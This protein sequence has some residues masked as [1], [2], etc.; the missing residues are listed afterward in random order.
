MIRKKPI[1]LVAIILLI[2]SIAFLILGISPT[3]VEIHHVNN[4]ITASI[5][6]RNFDNYFKRTVTTIDNVKYCS[7]YKREQESNKHRSTRKEFYYSVI[8]E[9]SDDKSALVVQKYNNPS[10]AND[11]KDKINDAIF[12]KTDLKHTFLNT[13]NIFVSFIGFLF[14]VIILFGGR[15]GNG[16]EYKLKD[17][18]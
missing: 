3:M 10:D 8:I 12:N 7:V 13:E 4:N 11:L 16:E 6:V 14:S 1:Y 18:K 5:S 17:K 2:T 9:S 15:N